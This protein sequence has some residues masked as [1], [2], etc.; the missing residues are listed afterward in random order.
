MTAAGSAR[1][2]LRP[3]HTY[4]IVARDPES[5]QLGVAVQSRY[6][7]VG[8]VVPWAEAGVG[9]VA[10]QSFVKVD[11]GPRGLA[12]MRL[13]LSARQALDA[14]LEQDSM[15]DVRQVAMVD[16]RGT[17]A[18][19]TG[20]KCIGAAG[21]LAGDGFAVQANL[22]VNESVWPAMKTAYERGAGD[23]GDRLVAALEAAQAAGG[24]IRGQQSAALL[25]VSGERSEQPW[26]GRLID[27]RVE[28]HPAPVVELKRLLRLH[29][30]YRLLDRFDELVTRGKLEEA[31]SVLEQCRTL[32]PEA[33]EPKLWAA[34]LLFASGQEDQ[35]LPLFRELFARTPALPELMPRLVRA[36][37][38]PN[39]P[40]G[41]ERILAQRPGSQR[42]TVSADG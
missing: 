33:D 35:A 27:L 5:G 20:A 4:S 19:H 29:R 21:H 42:P 2:P 28:D 14:L 36:G 31:W 6:F 9:A 24:D 30:A 37:L 1:R 39:D 11:Y 8:S 26:Q 7:S 22:M 15:R 12:L 23:L 10:T 18:I 40:A 41:L 32:A 25:V 38:L 3:A 17:V 34:V 13:G 16:A